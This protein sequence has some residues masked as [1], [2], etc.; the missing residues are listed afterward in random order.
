[1]NAQLHTL[2]PPRRQRALIYVRQSTYREESIS[3]ESQEHIAREYAARQGY[4]VVGVEADPGISGRTWQRRGV[5]AAMEALE[6]Q[7]VDV[8]VLWR[9]SRL[10]RSRKDWAIAADRADRVGGRIESATEPIDTATAA[11]RFQRGVMVELAAFESEQIGEQWREAHQYR[12]RQGLPPTGG[13]RY[14]YTRDDE[15]FYHP[16]PV[17]GPRLAEL[18]RSYLG[19]SGAAALTRRLNELEPDR[20]RPWTYQNVQQVLDS[21]FGAGLLGRTKPKLLPPWEREYRPGVH[22][23]V[24]D[25]ETWDAYVAQRA[26][27]T[28]PVRT[29]SPYLLSG[30]CRCGDCGSPM[31]GKVMDGRAI[32]MC[33]RASM[34]SGMRKVSI[35]A[36]RVEQQ[37]EKWLMEHAGDVDA[38]ARAQKAT[39][40]KRTETE[41]SQ[42]SLA[43][44]VEKADER[45]TKLV[46]KLADG[47]ITDEAYQLAAAALQQ[48]RKSAQQQLRRTAA[49]PVAA[50]APTRLPVDLEKVWERLTVPERNE[51]LRTMI[52]HVVIAPAAH[53]GS[54]ADRATIHARWESCSC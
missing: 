37:V 46:M 52:A 49:N 48:E 28:R 39:A 33:S 20:Q 12:V 8:V 31:H 42:R 53:R 47:T 10:S 34:T 29:R 17:T 32:Y 40:A 23:P 5:Q 14:G 41:F 6:A 24:I 13:P 44:R 50:A 9:W 38:R 3:L 26:A 1:M 45:L 27:R 11:G 18:Y 35:V 25:R 16:D 36:W 54:T 7:R 51:L 30:L 2:A 43:R 21:G 19:G 15:G 4:D 22:E